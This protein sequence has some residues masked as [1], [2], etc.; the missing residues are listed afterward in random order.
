MAETFRTNY[1]SEDT[2]SL[3]RRAER[4][5]GGVPVLDLTNWNAPI[6]TQ[7]VTIQSL[8][9]S[10]KRIQVKNIVTVIDSGIVICTGLTGG[11]GTTVPA[12][13]PSGVSPT[14]YVNMV[15]QVYAQAPQN[16]L[17]IVFDYLLDDVPMT[18]PPRTFNITTG[19]ISGAVLVYAFDDNV[20]YIESQTL[21]LHGVRQVPSTIP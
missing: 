19:G 15:A 20:Q 13:C 14:D 18:S 9:P 3:I 16:L 11:C 1:V 4:T 6:Y 2:A 12:N 21:T 17:N 7:G 10:C 5:L 8:A